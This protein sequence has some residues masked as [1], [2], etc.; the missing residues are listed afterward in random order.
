MPVSWPGKADAHCVLLP[1]MLNPILLR[2][3]IVNAPL[4]Y[5]ENKIGFPQKSGCD[6]FLRHPLAR[7]GTSRIILR[8]MAYV[9]IGEFCPGHPKI[10]IKKGAPPQ[11]L[12]ELGSQ[13]TT[14][15]LS[16]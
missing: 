10:H 8:E 5:L 3:G 14:D 9:L 15:P 6:F 2:V 4:R 1:W 11:L 13:S 7:W 16:K 12:I